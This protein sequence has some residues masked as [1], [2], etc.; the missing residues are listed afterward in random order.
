MC[1]VLLW[2][3]L[4]FRYVEVRW[5]LECTSLRRMRRSVKL[6]VIP[7]AITCCLSRI[8]E[9]EVRP[10][11]YTIHRLSRC[12]IKITLI[13]AQ[14]SMLLVVSV[15]SLLV[16]EALQLRC[17]MLCHGLIPSAISLFLQLHVSL[18]LDD[19][20]LVEGTKTGVVLHDIAILNTALG[21]CKLLGCVE[22]GVSFMD[23]KS[24]RWFIMAA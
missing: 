24:L 19:S 1:Q 11:E 23:M 21:C 20:A 14:I 10:I 18:L 12:L 3:L 17:L 5:G 7:Q 15:Q 8:W 6:L 16:F 22:H 9:H 4:K 2:H 13:Y